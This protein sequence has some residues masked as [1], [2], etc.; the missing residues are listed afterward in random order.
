MQP[1]L[2]EHGLCNLQIHMESHKRLRL[3]LLL[4][5][6]ILITATVLFIVQTVSDQQGGDEQDVILTEATCT[7][8]GGYWNECGSACP[9]DKEAPCIALCV[10]VCECASDDQCPFAWTCQYL[11]DEIGV[12]IEK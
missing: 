10:E 11:Y 2:S 8:A 3:Y 6:V 9:E 7:A 5:V 12:C 4:F 1:G